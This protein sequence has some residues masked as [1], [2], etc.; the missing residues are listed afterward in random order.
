MRIVDLLAKESILLGQK[1]GSKDEAID[2]LIDLQMR[3]GKIADRETYKQG[4]I[5][6]EKMSSTAVGEGIAIP[7]APPAAVPSRSASE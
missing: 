6:R 7:H 4:I 2:L 1:P 3:G 5:M